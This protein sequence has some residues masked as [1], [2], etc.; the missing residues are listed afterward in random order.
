MCKNK[1]QSEQI[2]TQVEGIAERVTKEILGQTVLN[3][4]N[5]DGHSFS[6]RP[7]TTCQTIS[8]IVE[9]PF[10]CVKKAADAA[11]RAK[12]RAD[13]LWPYDEGSIEEA[14]YEFANGKT[15]A[16]RE[17]WW[18]ILV[19]RRGNEPEIVNKS[20]WVDVGDLPEEAKEAYR[21]YVTKAGL[22]NGEHWS[23]TIGESSD[24]SVVESWIG[25]E[26]RKVIDAALIAAG[27][28]DGYIIDLVF[29][30]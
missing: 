13:F 23:Y 12:D 4:L 30:W 3:L 21:E 18:D 27:L 9:K 17:Q 1:E 28:G 29:S 6:K 14:G 24:D 2:K 10:G 26:K 22:H 20:Y 7:C 19:A 25:E 11:E 8:A 15:E 16:Y 5:S